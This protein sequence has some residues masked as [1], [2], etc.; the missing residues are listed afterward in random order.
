[1]GNEDR[2]RKA[3]PR[4]EWSED[5][6]QRQR[7]YKRRERATLAADLPRDV[8]DR[9]RDYCS[10]RGLSVSA[11]IAEYI[12]SVVGR[13]TDRTGSGSDRQ[14]A[15]EADRMDQGDRSDDDTPGDV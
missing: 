7:D 15:A 6:R 4:S 12:Y 8:A 9:F 1:M 5:A 2:R 11:T 13:E 10:E 14:S 3:R